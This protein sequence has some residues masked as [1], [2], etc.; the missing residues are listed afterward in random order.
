MLLQAGQ[1]GVAPAANVA[2]VGFV[3]DD[4]FWL[5]EW[6]LLRLLALL[7]LLESH[8]H[9]LELEVVHALELSI[10]KLIFSILVL[11]E[12]AFVRPAAG[13]GATVR[14]DSTRT[15]SLFFVF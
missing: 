14:E 9:A 1:V 4:P 3:R 10:G 8:V 2:H 5:V 6:G 13:E 11:P 15:F 12:M 7:L